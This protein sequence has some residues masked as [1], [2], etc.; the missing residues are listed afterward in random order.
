[1]GQFVLSTVVRGGVSTVLVFLLIGVAGAQVM[2]STNYAIQSDSVNV[3]GGNS[4][5]TNYGLESTTGEIATGNSSSTN[6]Q[7]RAGYQQMQEVF[8]SISAAADVT[9]QPA[10]GGLTGGVASGTTA[11]LV[12]TDSPS[13]YQLL[14]QASGN[15]AMRSGVYTI[16]NYAPVGAV[17]D[18]TFITD[19]T[20]VQF[21]YSPEGPD[22]ALRFQDAGSVC[23]VAGGDT[24]RRCWDGLSTT[25]V[26]IAT[27]GN[28]NHPSGA[29]TTIQFQVGIGGSIGVPP[30]TYVA[31]TTLTALPL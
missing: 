24:S 26:T 3:G 10:L 20:D 21:G 23:G 15:P 13:G 28:A 6:Y 29:T 31:T 27:N 14:I 30:G 7:L 5:S 8:M 4:T 25:P 17:P 1:M 22:V 16:A 19:P 2:S 12:T 11:V 18:F 9:L